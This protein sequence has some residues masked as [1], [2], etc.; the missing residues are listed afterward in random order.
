V[1][2]EVTES[3]HE[4]A[5][6]A[7]V[8]RWP[9]RP[10]LPTARLT[11]SNSSARF[12]FSSAISFSVSAILPASPVF[13][14]GIRTEKSPLRMDVRTMSSCSRSSVSG[15]AGVRLAERFAGRPLPVVEAC[16]MGTPAGDTIQK[17]TSEP[18]HSENAVL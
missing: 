7:S 8:A 18:T 1:F 17:G 9:I 2:T 4:P 14:T 6:P 10:S 15:A 12:S 11:R 13:D 5:A 16:G 3:A